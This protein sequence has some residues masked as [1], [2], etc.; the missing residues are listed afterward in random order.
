MSSDEISV[1][2]KR[3]HQHQVTHRFTVSRTNV[4]LFVG[5]NSHKKFSKTKTRT[6]KKNDQA[7]T[8]IDSKK[9]TATNNK[10]ESSNAYNP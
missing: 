8:N 1:T 10:N 7:S 2:A 9:P 4:F 5:E 3:A 6:R